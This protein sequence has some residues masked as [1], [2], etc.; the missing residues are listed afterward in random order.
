[1]QRAPGCRNPVGD[2][3]T[4]QDLYS[5]NYRPGPLLLESWSSRALM[6][7]E[8]IFLFGPSADTQV[9]D[10]EYREITDGAIDSE[11]ILDA[12]KRMGEF[13]K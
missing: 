3:C 12:M 13:Y 1:M 7:G 11:A 5:S 10:F 6:T 9:L 4:D 8:R 2:Y